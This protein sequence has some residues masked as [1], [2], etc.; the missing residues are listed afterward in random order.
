MS[1]GTIAVCWRAGLH[2]EIKER[3]ETQGGGREE[4]DTEEWNEGKE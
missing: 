3:V 2:V 1:I 4:Q